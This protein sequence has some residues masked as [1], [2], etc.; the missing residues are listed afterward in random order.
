MQSEENEKTGAKVISFINMKGG[1]GKTTLT[2]NIADQLVKENYKVLVIDMDPQFNATQ[3]LLLHKVMLENIETTT[4]D[5]TNEKE[6]SVGEK[7]IEQEIHST[8]LYDKLE[9]EG[10]TALQ[11][12]QQGSMVEEKNIVFNIKEGLD[13]IAG[14]LSLSEEISGDTVNKDS[15]IKSYLIKKELIYKYH[16]I[17]IDCPPTWS[18]LTH[19]S[20]FASDYYIIPSKIDLYS[21]LGINLLSK[22][23]Q[24]KL[25][26][27][28][29]YTQKL[30]HGEELIN[31][32][33]VFT[34]VHKNIQAEKRRKKT[35]TKKIRK[36]NI[37]ILGTEIPHFPSASTK[38]IVYNDIKDNRN[39]AELTN[40]IE[41]IT[42][43]II[44]KTAVKEGASFGR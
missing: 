41:K 13:L 20:L 44:D 28:Y 12:F 10:K 21:S 6:Y 19:T 23:I 31:L 36:A 1:V 38:L 40:S 8:D 24:E 4:S 3:S 43:E 27:T 30:E 29:S 17:L 42:K 26:N 18:I 34:L 32:G 9:K 15:A 16:Y 33:V 39:Y 35:V 14:D 25:L 7:E 5:L 22:K 2:I 37:P 11:F